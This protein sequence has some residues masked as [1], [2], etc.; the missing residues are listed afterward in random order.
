MMYA[1]NDRISLRQYK[2]LIVFDLLS[3]VCLVIPYVISNCAGYDGLPV[4]V[5]GAFFTAIYFWFLLWVMTKVKG[6]YFGYSSHNIGKFLTF[7]VALLYLIKTMWSLILLIRLFGE[8]I[9]RTLLLES[10][11]FLIVIPM[12]LVAGYLAIKGCEVRARVSEVLYFIVLVPI[13]IFLI[14]SLYKI[15][16]A[17][18]TPIV[19]TPFSDMLRG[20]YAL[21]ILFNLLELQIL[22]KPYIKEKTSQKAE[23]KRMASYGFQ[24]LGIIFVVILLFF[25]LT[26]GMIGEGAS[27]DTLYSSV[28]IMQM[29]EL[30]GTFLNRQDSLVLALWLISIFS[31]L[32]GLLYYSG[33]ALKQMVGAKSLNQIIGVLMAISIILSLVPVD[34][35]EFFEYYMRYMAYIGVPQSILL[36]LL[37]IIVAKVRGGKKDVGELEDQQQNVREKKNVGV[38]KTIS[39]IFL[40]MILSLTL[41]SCS[42]R[43]EIEDRDF[44]QAIGLDYKDGLITMYY[45][46]PDLQA[47][48]DQGPTDNKEALI[49]TFSGND[50]FDI[51]E[52]Y[53]LRSA[54]RLDYSHLKAVVFGQDFC[55]SPQALTMFIN[56][57]DSTYKLSKNTYVFLSKTSAKDIVQLNE[58]TDGGIGDYLERLYKNSLASSEKQEI[59]LGEMLNDKN[60]LD[61]CMHIPILDMLEDDLVVQGE[62]IILNGELRYQISGK[63][64]IYTDMIRGFGE[65]S[66]VFLSSNDAGS[67]SFVVRLNQV[68]NQTNLIMEDGSPYYRIQVEASGIVEKGLEQLKGTNIETMEYNIDSLEE[69][70][71][72]QIKQEILNQLTILIKKD[73]I[74]YLNILRES[75][76]QS[77]EMYLKYRENATQF[78]QDLQFDVMVSVQL[79]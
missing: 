49:K 33:I 45:V 43:I 10:T 7:F 67:P 39:S 41:M 42:R 26:V 51:E 37:I 60:N 66:R 16:L 13:V 50:F 62:G 23:V 1:N 22:L 3:I 21:F 71:N 75:R 69:Y 25:V 15:D 44:V 52:Q 72:Q 76:Y 35:E 46:L 74:D 12:V 47:L 17:N 27:R 68:Q 63:A 8:V 36:P 31:V 5:V 56:Y 6:S 57:A 20:G 73:G 77:K 65:N 4:I 9:N 18:L 58:S 14:F 30:P 34:L 32:S 61:Y 29:I 40:V 19:A 55:Q 11:R 59:T 64:S 28:K 53:K 24:A 48:T 78:L 70:M 38:V 2:R 79:N 54:K